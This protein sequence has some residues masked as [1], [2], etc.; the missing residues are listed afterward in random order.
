MDVPFCATQTAFLEQLPI[1]D[2]SV[3]RGVILAQLAR[4]VQ[5]QKSPIWEP[6]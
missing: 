2:D 3:W 1:W 4:H 6:K 5:I